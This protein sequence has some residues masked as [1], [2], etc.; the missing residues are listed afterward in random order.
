MKFEFD[1]KATN[2]DNVKADDIAYA[3][4]DSVSI[5]EEEITPSALKFLN[6]FI[7]ALDESK[8]NNVLAISR[9]SISISKQSVIDII[10]AEHGQIKN[11]LLRKW[12]QQSNQYFAN[13][14]EDV[15]LVSRKD[16]YILTFGA[17]FVQPNA[18]LIKRS[19]DI[20][21]QTKP[22]DYE[23]P[24]AIGLPE[25]LV[26][27]SH[28][29]HTDEIHE[30]FVSFANDLELALKNLK[31]PWVDKFTLK[32]F[33]DCSPDNGFA[34]HTTRQTQ[35]DN[36][37]EEA[38]VGLIL[39]SDPYDKSDACQR[40]LAYFV[41][42]K[43]E[44]HSP[45]QSIVILEH[46]R[47]QDM[48][49]RYTARNLALPNNK[50]SLV[51]FWE[52]S[53]VA[54]K[55]SFVADLRDKICLAIDDYIQ[56]QPIHKHVER[57]E[58][59]PLSTQVA[60]RVQS[61]NSLA[62]T[63]KNSRDFDPAALEEPTAFSH[64]SSSDDSRLDIVE[65][66]TNWCNAD[67]PDTPR[68]TALLGDFG[69]GKTITCRLLTYRL[70]ENYKKDRQNNPL[71]IYLDLKGLLANLEDH[72]TSP[73]EHL[74]DTMLSS[75]GQEDISG[76]LL[77]DF[78]RSSHCLVIFDGFDEIG[79]K[80]SVEKQQRIYHKLL[81]IIPNQIYKDDIK[82]LK[83][84]KE[85]PEQETSLSDFP[86]KILVSC[87]THFFNRIEIEKQFL[88]GSHRHVIGDKAIQVSNIQRFYMAPFSEKSIKQFLIRALGETQGERAIS[89]INNVH[90]LSE[91]SSHPI[92]LDLISRHLPN[93]IA[94]QEQGRVVNAAILYLQI[95][96]SIGQRDIEKHLIRL[97]DK[98]ELLASLALY[99]WQNQ[100]T[101]MSVKKLEKWFIDYGNDHSVIMNQ[102]KGGIDNIELMFQDL[103]TASLLVRDEHNY[104]RFSH[105]SYLEFFRALGVF[106]AI[107]AANNN[108]S[109]DGIF[110][111]REGDSQTTKLGNET[112][113]FLLDWRD[114]CEPEDR[115]DFDQGFI[116]LMQNSA[117]V[118]SKEVGFGIWLAGQRHTSSF[119]HC[120]NPD[121]S[122]LRFTEQ[123][124]P[125]NLKHLDLSKANLQH[126][127]FD[128][129]RFNEL[130]L[131]QATFDHAK[132]IQ[133]YVYHCQIKDSSWADSQIHDTSWSGESPQGPSSN[134]QLVQA[135][136][137][138]IKW[139]KFYG[140]RD[141]V[142]STAFSPDG[143]CIISGSDDG[144]VKVWDSV[145]GQCIHSL[146]EHN[147]SVTSV[148]FSPDGKHI[149]SGSHDHTVKLWD[150]QSG[151]CIHSLSEHSSRVTSVAFSP[152]GKHIVSGSRD[153]TVKLWN[154]QSGQCLRT[155]DKHAGGINSV[156]LSP[157]GKHIV[158]G[159]NDGTI[160]LWNSQS[161]Q[162][163]YSVDVSERGVTTLT[164][165]PNGNQ[166][167]S[168]DSGSTIRILDSQSG[169]CMYALIGHKNLVKNVAFSPDGKYIVS[170]A[171]DRVIKI[172]DSQSGQSLKSLSSHRNLPMCAAF[173]PDGNY[174]VSGGYRNSI[175]IWDRQS[176]LRMRSLEG[177]QRKYSYL[178]L[179]SDG[180]R[181]ISSTN[182]NIQLWDRRSGLRLSELN[183]YKYGYF[184]E[185][186]SSDG[187]HIIGISF[188]DTI[189][190]WDTKYDLC[191][192][193]LDGHESLVNSVAFSPDKKH[194][195]SGYS[196]HT[197]K[198]WDSQSGQCLQ[199][200][201]AKEGEEKNGRGV[202]SLA[203]SPDGKYI[204]SGSDDNTVQLWNCQTGQCL[205]LLDEHK[206]SVTCVVFSP[207]GQH[208][209]SSSYDN[210]IKLWHCQTGKCLHTFEG[211]TN[212]VTH[213]AFCPNGKHIVSGANDKTI[214]LWDSQSR[215]CLHTFKGHTNRVYNVAISPTGKH[216]VSSDLDGNIK[217]WDIESARQIRNTWLLDDGYIISETD[218][219][220]VLQPTTFQG[221][222]WRFQRCIGDKGNRLPA[223][224][225]P[226][227]DKRYKA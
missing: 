48:S 200:L 166:I 42:E 105:T 86:S 174:I 183:V 169:E 109:F 123:F 79:Q 112:I 40:E 185:T 34:V 21:E 182:D 61:A 203:F 178:A 129:V 5:N 134:Y 106:N 179:S 76:E 208:I 60:E 165:S 30:Y 7:A 210:T 225:H 160:K 156:A 215:K 132:L 77:I 223:S 113:R 196:D 216:I 211:H 188:D 143:R 126:C 221:S 52:G 133:C 186:F 172:W 226:D 39:W 98:Q 85:F 130:N 119:P 62:I 80:L 161:G 198:I 45:K 192:L 155:L 35:Q 218:K 14:H 135:Q 22:E 43:G 199:S 193:T 187:R 139:E 194:I 78:I 66:L 190:L 222:A 110:S 136:S 37:C 189:Q 64:Q 6:A 121:W 137:D 20:A 17:N 69:F 175:E 204:V 207:D 19:L 83:H 122:Q 4:E 180:E 146:N 144:T 84:C 171:Y 154:S 170:T 219:K 63:D 24:T 214:K 12:V 162:C 114:G 68:V 209:V 92:M 141:I 11:D 3:I 173:S 67:Q 10:H 147:S 108:S 65:H 176:G 159:A 57:T 23:R 87:R 197:I 81:D 116:L 111:R 33:Y 74:L 167:A 16:A 148:A 94:L 99:L 202:T 131:D 15:S 152:D 213:V 140:H 103:C 124:I 125:D 150:S 36:R 28:K 168:G 93:L 138:N 164:F 117:M 18:K 1:A 50:K 127:Y 44:N 177:S 102:F 32:L 27:I 227:W 224:A 90:D 25:Y 73:I 153:S 8:D 157:D 47:M 55:H 26:F 71:P 41:D 91:L 88:E 118:D 115:E 95:F 145:S 206:S 212:T 97:S 120:N 96:D 75:T 163:L 184:K 191:L 181:I 195:V 142:N 101:T 128:L 89:L 59:V 49:A 53:G 149:V 9:N 151:H 100:K 201:E 220:G 38:A 51:G 46:G 82:R 72:L 13:N 31:T 29:W 158:S 2:K 56:A 54:E 70:G 58:K 205:H 217:L 104:Y 107:A